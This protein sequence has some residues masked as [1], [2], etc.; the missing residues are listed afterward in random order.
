MP[1]P[2]FVSIQFNKQLQPIHM[3]SRS[4]SPA[5]QRNKE[6][7]ASDSDISKHQKILSSMKQFMDD[8]TNEYNE[9][10]KR[11][12]CNRIDFHFFFL[13]IVLFPCISIFAYRTLEI[14]KKRTD[15]VESNRLEKMVN[16][17]DSDGRSS[18][19]FYD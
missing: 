12:G 18:K 1:I 4:T 10:K 11:F 19:Y 8:M 5:I 6:S 3:R 9:S 2:L 14:R 13:Q 17:A 16:F 7:F 15:M